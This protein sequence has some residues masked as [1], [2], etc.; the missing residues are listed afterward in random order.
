MPCFPAF[1]GLAAFFAARSAC[2]AA[3]TSSNFFEIASACA[4]VIVHALTRSARTVA[5]T[6]PLLTPSCADA[7]PVDPAVSAAIVIATAANLFFDD[8]CISFR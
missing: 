4:C 3:R 2:L 5:F 8:I 1:A 7:I 6:K